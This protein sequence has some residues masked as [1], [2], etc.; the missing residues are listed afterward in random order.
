M[1][2]PD[3]ILGTWSHHH[4][5]TASKQAHLSI[6]DA[7]DSYTGWAKETKYDIFLQGS[8]KNDTNLR[9]DSDVDVVVQLAAKLRPR[10]AVLSGNQLEQDQP[11]KLAYKRWQSFRE[12]V[13]RALRVTYGKAVT[14]GR[15]SL[16]LTKGKI[17]ASA[18]VVVTLHCETGITFYLPGEHRWVVSYPQQHYTRG[19]KKERGTEGRY[20]R[21]VRMFKAA[22][23]HLVKNDAISGGTAPSY[24]IE[25]LLYNVP[26]GLFKSS[27]GQS[28]SGIMEY[29][30]ATEI[31]RFECQNGVREL[32]G[33]S[34]D[35][36]SV[37]KAHKYIRAL[38][39][40]WVKW[41]EST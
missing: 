5:G 14:S 27:L 7:L 28:Y 37:K 31:Q 16:K 21:T 17:P 23:N 40:L 3:S 2:I 41:P 39:R 11:H 32:F 15:K 1:P 20:K 8:Y 30:A 12:Q 33:P 36:W 34:R 25:C 18:D 4:P 19:L 26:D 13:L 29:L 9:R 24:F 10:V 35:L 6:R 38:E 22:R